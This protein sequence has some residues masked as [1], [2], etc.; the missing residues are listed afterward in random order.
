M[1]EH[2]FPGDDSI[3]GVQ[4]LL[5]RVAD[6]MRLEG[7]VSA[8]V[9]DNMSLSLVSGF[10]AILDHYGKLLVAR[11]REAA[12]HIGL[13]VCFPASADALITRFNEVLQDYSIEDAMGA[14]FHNAP[15][16]IWIVHDAGAL[17]DS[18]IQLLARLVQHFPGANIRV[19]MLFNAASQKQ[20]LLAAFGRRILSWEI[21][22]P[23]DEQCEILMEQARAQ[24]R[25]GVVGA[26]L[27]QISPQKKPPLHPMAMPEMV[28]E[29]PME[30]PAESK[31]PAAP[32]QPETVRPESR[33]SRKV[34]LWA[35]LAAVL[36]LVCGF[37]VSL[38]YGVIPTGDRAVQELRALLRGDT[39]HTK[40]ANSAAPSSAAAD[41]ASKPSPT[42][43]GV[44]AAAAVASAAQAA[45]VTPPPQT[46]AVKT[47]EEVE[48]IVP[49]SASRS[50][51]PVTAPNT[52]PAPVAKEVK[53][54][55]KAPDE[56]TLAQSQAGQAWVREMPAGTFLVQ[57][58]I[59]PSYAE[60]NTWL[61]AHPSLRRARIVANYLPNLPTLQYSVVSG[62]FSS[63]SDASTYADTPGMPKDPQIRSARF[64]KEQFS[65]DNVVGPKQRRG[66]NKR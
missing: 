24:G 46:P 57:H 28:A 62:P 49:S 37:V 48:T 60:A 22:P 58:T 13:E 26:L 35:S 2:H 38:L 21:E 54:A 53:E 16:K 14:K 33:P 19:V 9:Q 25:E 15:P 43:D 6:R 5:F 12:P 66:E 27:R 47:M 10:D 3:A 45:T 59:V 4:P 44:N 23:T 61:Q 7:Y 18:E 40:P 8:L 30:V 56:T 17:P 55:P 20:K 32:A 36:L 29:P 64:M 51:G 65:Q 63:L 50:K 1:N 42:T 39:A 52:P 31:A 11:L 41:A 34:W